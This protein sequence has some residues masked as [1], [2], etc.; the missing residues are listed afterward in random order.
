[1]KAS[2]F[3]RELRELSP[4]D[5]RKLAGEIIASAEGF[6]AFRG[7]LDRYA[8]RAIVTHDEKLKASGKLGDR[9]VLEK[10]LDKIEAGYKAK[11]RESELGFHLRIKAAEAGIDATLFDGFTFEDEAAIEAKVEAMR[12]HDKQ[13]AIA[14]FGKRAAQFKPGSGVGPRTESPFAGFPDEIRLAAESFKRLG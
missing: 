12:E 1:M 4:D 10:R 9:A 14:D 5:A 7:E 13:V 11:L 8:S 2:D 6:A 3:L